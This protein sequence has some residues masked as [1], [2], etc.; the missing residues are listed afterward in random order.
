MVVKG[1]QRRAAVQM[2]VLGR[3]PYSIDAKNT[4]ASYECALRA[5]I[6]PIASGNASTA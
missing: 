2:P 6:M 4:P 3:F 1:I 5:L